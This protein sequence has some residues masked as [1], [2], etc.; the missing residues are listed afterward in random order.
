MREGKRSVGGLASGGGRVLVVSRVEKEV[1][2]KKG[3]SDAEESEWVCVK[4]GCVQSY[5]SRRPQL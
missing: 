4:R 5:Y 2:F 1:S 3:N